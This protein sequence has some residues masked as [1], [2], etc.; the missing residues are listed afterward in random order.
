MTLSKERELFARGELVF[1]DNLS[2]YCPQSAHCLW[3]LLVHKHFFFYLN[4][5]VELLPIFQKKNWMCTEALFMGYGVNDSLINGLMCLLK[6]YCVPS[7]KRMYTHSK[8]SKSKS[9]EIYRRMYYQEWLFFICLHW[10]MY[11][12]LHGQFVV[13]LSLYWLTW[14]PWITQCYRSQQSTEVIKF[15]R[16]FVCLH[17]LPQLNWA[18]DSFHNNVATLMFCLNRGFSLLHWRLQVLM[19]ILKRYIRNIEMLK[20]KRIH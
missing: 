6:Y 15:Y 4:W 10:S 11:L 7:T 12:H 1:G 19:L 14:V 5:K 8:P 17:G 18:N 20:Y 9:K 16:L 2:F 3:F 13:G